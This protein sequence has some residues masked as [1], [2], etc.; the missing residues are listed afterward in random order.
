M[1]LVISELFV[2]SGGKNRVDIIKYN[3]KE[4]QRKLDLKNSC[5]D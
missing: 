4:L 2:A 3:L 1:Y 5:K